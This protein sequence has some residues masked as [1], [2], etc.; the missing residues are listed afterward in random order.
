MKGDEITICPNCGKETTMKDYE[1]F[2]LIET[3]TVGGM[4]DCWKCGYQGLPIIVKKE[5]LEKIDFPND[6]YAEE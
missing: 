6:E 5:D 3:A 2:V 4:I 1:Q